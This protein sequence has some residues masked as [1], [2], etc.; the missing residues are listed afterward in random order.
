MR[1]GAKSNLGV[2][3][4]AGRSKQAEVQQSKMSG[5]DEDGRGEEGGEERGD[6]KRSVG[7][8]DVAPVKAAGGGWLAGRGGG[9]DVM[10]GNTA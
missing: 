7:P 5:D 6:E 4:Y 10:N 2:G 3:F 8:G 9:G 1:V